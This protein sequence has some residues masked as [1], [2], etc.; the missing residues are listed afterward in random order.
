M[1]KKYKKAIKH[2]LDNFNFGYAYDV[3]V[4]TWRYH[5]D[6]P[7]IHEFEDTARDLLV[8]VCKDKKCKFIATG[9]FEVKRT[10]HTLSLKF[11]IE[12]WDTEI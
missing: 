3:L 1:K 12:D 10:K 2:I 5:S 7:D 6:V 9:G 4:Y 8:R 11:V